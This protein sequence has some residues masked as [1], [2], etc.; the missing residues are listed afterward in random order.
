MMDRNDYNNYSY[1]INGLLIFGTI[2]L[3]NNQIHAHKAKC[4]RKIFGDIFL[5][6]PVAKPIA[7]TTGGSDPHG[8]A[9]REESVILPE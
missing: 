9:L 7:D 4:P 1:P 6:Y 2:D 8:S 5:I 3:S